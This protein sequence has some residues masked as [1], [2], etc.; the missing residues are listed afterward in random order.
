[1][2]VSG[3]LKP[4]MISIKGND[5]TELQRHPM[6]LCKNSQTSMVWWI[7]KARLNSPNQW[8]MSP[9]TEKQQMMPV[10][11]WATGQALRPLLAGDNVSTFKDD[12]GNNIDVNVRLNDD[13]RQTISQLQSMYLS[14]SRMDSNGQ[15]ILIPLSQVA[16]FSE[17]LALQINRRS[18][19]REVVVQANTD[20]RP[21]GDIGADITNI[22]NE[23]KLP[24]GYSFAVQ[25]SNKDMAESIGYATTALDWQSCLFICC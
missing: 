2:A 3:G 22:Q 21:A 17:T 9:L 14:S 6:S 8:S 15:P 24:P 1:M 12:N 19:F 4:I 23:M 10:F 18:L 11:D 25:G 13:N 16:N 5:L 7:W 20:G